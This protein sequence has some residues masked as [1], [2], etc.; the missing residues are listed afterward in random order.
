MEWVIKDEEMMEHN[1]QEIDLLPMLSHYSYLDFTI[2]LNVRKESSIIT[3]NMLEEVK[4]S[5]VYEKE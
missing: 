5:K 4:P 2:P 1:L 3:T